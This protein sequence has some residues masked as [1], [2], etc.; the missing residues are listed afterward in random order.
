[1][2]SRLFGKDY[3]NTFLERCLQSQIS[4]HME[5]ISTTLRITIS[6]GGA[7]GTVSPDTAMHLIDTLRENLLTDP[8]IQRV[9]V[10]MRRWRHGTHSLDLSFC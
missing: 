8:S 2:E 7:Y 1:M 9:A 10:Y 4:V 3:V 5:P 6:T